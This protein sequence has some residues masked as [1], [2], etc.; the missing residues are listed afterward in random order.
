[1]DS[2]GGIFFIIRTW[3]GETFH[4]KC[5]DFEIEKKKPAF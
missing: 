4:D 5:L 2:H 3:L 1:M